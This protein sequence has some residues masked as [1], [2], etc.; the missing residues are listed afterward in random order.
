MQGHLCGN[1]GD[2]T[3]DLKIETWRMRWCRGPLAMRPP[4]TA[5]PPSSMRGVNHAGS[6]VWQHTRSLKLG[7]SEV[8]MDGIFFFHFQMP[9]T[10]R[11]VTHAGLHGIHRKEGWES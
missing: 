8:V 10:T 5:K 2:N 4:G 1:T 7:M 11:E 9:S 6:P 3:E